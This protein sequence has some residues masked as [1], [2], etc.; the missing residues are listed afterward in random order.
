MKKGT[1]ESISRRVQYGL[2]GLAL[3]IFLLFFLVGYNRPSLLDPTFNDPLF[4]PVVLIFALLLV[5]AALAVVVWSAV[6]AHRNGGRE[7]KVENGIPKARI[8]RIVVIALAAAL[9][10]FFVT[11]STAAIQI[12]GKAFTDTFWLRAADMFIRTSG[13]LLLVA[14]GAAVYMQ[15]RKRK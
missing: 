5:V 7:A 1:A 2:I 14:I 12:N 15:V 4:T 6:L 11:A 13:L 9:L 10:L 8:A 3:L